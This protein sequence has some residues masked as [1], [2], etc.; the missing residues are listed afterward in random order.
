MYFRIKSTIHGN[1][2]I[3]FF[4]TL[5]N[6]FLEKGHQ[7]TVGHEHEHKHLSQIFLKSPSSLTD[8]IT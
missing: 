5:V 8:L 2:V 1:Q 6:F 4:L 3:I 7:I